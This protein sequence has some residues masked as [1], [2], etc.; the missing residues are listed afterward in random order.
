MMMMMTIVMMM[1]MMMMSCRH[2]LNYAV[3]Y[4]AAICLI[5]NE[6]MI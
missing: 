5:P 1:M 4:Y 6:P 3:V 2:A